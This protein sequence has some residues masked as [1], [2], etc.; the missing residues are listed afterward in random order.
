LQLSFGSAHPGITQMV[1][2]DGHLEA[3]Q[4]DIDSKVWSD[5]GTRASQVLTSS[6]APPR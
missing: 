1:F 5:Y 3:V 4:Q 2:C 6:G